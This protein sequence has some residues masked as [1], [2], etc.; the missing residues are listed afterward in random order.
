MSFIW[1]AA[2]LS[3]PGALGTGREQP[4]SY[5]GAALRVAADRVAHGLPMVASGE[6]HLVMTNIAMENPL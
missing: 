6:Y 5:R 4:I 3:V 2:L 1:P